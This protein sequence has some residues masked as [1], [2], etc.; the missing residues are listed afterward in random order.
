MKDER[1]S[2]LAVFMSLMKRYDREPHHALQVARLATQLFDELVPLHRLDAPD[3]HYLEAAALVHDIGWTQSSSAHHKASQKMILKSELPGWSDE[4]KLII[5]NVARYHRKAPP[6]ISHKAYAALD[7]AAQER[8]RRLAAL[9]RVA[10]GLDRSHRNIVRRLRCAIGD[11][12]VRLQ[13]YC[14]GDLG[15]ELYGV[16][17]KKDLFRTVFDRDLIVD[18]VYDLSLESDKAE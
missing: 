13:L 11:S 15:F 7:E 5:A 9:L 1:H 3:R 6:K 4:E 10:D 12:A 17:K 14:R 18:G 2:R 16:D 8:V